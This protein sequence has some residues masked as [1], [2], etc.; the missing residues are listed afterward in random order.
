MI[1]KSIQFKILAF[2]AVLYGLYSASEGSGAGKKFAELEKGGV[3]VPGILETAKTRR[4]TRRST[5]YT[6]VAS[7]TLQTG[8][9]R[10]TEFEVTSDFL[11]SRTNGDGMTGMITDPNVEIRYLPA[12]PGLAMIVGGSLNNSSKFWTG[13]GIAAAGL[14]GL[15]Y[16]FIYDPFAD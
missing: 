4:S 11:Q 14:I 12:K 5:D 7:Y 10:K 2:F 16:M 1:P 9:K 3:N 8:E 6:V 15:V 13:L